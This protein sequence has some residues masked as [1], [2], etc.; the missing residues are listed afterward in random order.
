MLEYVHCVVS[1]VSVGLQEAAG[2]SWLQGQQHDSR[3][4]TAAG[5]Q[6]E[7]VLL[8]GLYRM[9]FYCKRI[10]ASAAAVEAAYLPCFCNVVLV[11]LATVRIDTSTT[12]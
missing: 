2:V 7:H 12:F 9:I 6:L 8:C 3:I 1:S 11:W 5:E 10:G 4:E